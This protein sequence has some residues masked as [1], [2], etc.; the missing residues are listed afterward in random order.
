M[1]DLDLA[2][3]IDLGLKLQLQHRSHTDEV[4]AVAFLKEREKARRRSFRIVFSLLKELTTQSR[5][6]PLLEL[7]TFFWQSF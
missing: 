2:F 4:V 5:K 7:E 3:L 1:T 6:E